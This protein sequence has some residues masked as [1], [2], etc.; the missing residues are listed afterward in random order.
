MATVSTMGFGKH[1]AMGI[2]ESINKL[3]PGDELM[4]VAQ[5]QRIIAAQQLA[6]GIP[7]E[8]WRIEMGK[9]KTTALSMLH[10]IK[11]E[12]NDR[13]GEVDSWIENKVVTSFLKRLDRTVTIEVTNESIDIKRVV[14]ELH[15]RGFAA[16]LMKSF[17]NETYLEVT[18]PPQ[19]E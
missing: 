6:A 3:T 9:M 16:K 13:A 5:H 1:F 12:E 18:I 7:A 8:S 15:R 4:A 2:G 14:D 10:M 17:R 19:G 11:A